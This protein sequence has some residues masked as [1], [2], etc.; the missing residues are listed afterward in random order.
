MS[1]LMTLHTE[2]SSLRRRSRHL[3]RRWCLY[4]HCLWG[5]LE[6]D[7]ERRIKWEGSTW[8]GRMDG[9]GS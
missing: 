6:K 4:Y 7:R 2:D 8:W 1:L 9:L 3:G 5:F